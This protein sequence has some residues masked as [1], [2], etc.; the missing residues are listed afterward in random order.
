MIRVSLIILACLT[1]APAAA[2]DGAPAFEPAPDVLVERIECTNWRRDYIEQQFRVLSQ[3]GDTGW[4]ITHQ[5]FKEAGD[6]LDAFES[7]HIRPWID[8]D[9]QAVLAQTYWPSGV[10][11][12][13]D[14]WLRCG[15]Y[16]DPVFLRTPADYLPA[17]PSLEP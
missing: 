17:L 7:A 5:I 1:A 3:R 4:T 8:A 14:V 16:Q 15:H 6:D 12:S 13:E 10:Q 11:D 2:F 9:T